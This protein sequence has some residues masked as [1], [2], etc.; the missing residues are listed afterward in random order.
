MKKVTSKVKLFFTKIKKN[1]DGKDEEKVYILYFY[2]FFIPIEKQMLQLK[3][4]Y[5]VTISMLNIFFWGKGAVGA[6]LVLI[7][8]MLLFIT[9]YSILSHFQTAKFVTIF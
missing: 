9:I 7:L 5:S 2:Y 4:C 3:K 8:G 6:Y 1:Y